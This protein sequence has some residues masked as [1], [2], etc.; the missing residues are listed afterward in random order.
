MSLYPKLEDDDPLAPI[1]ASVKTCQNYRTVIND[2]LMR[3]F[4][5]KSLGRLSEFLWWPRQMR[6]NFRVKVYQQLLELAND[7]QFL[8]RL[9]VVGLWPNRGWWHATCCSK[10][11]VK[12]ERAETDR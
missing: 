4:G 9:F 12:H 7:E 5:R 2:E 8:R 11:E 1:I 10:N 6:E 3:R